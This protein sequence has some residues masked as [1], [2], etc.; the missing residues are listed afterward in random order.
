MWWQLHIYVN[1]LKTVKCTCYVGELYVNC[2]SIKLFLKKE[3][4]MQ[5]VFREKHREFG[6]RAFSRGVLGDKQRRCDGAR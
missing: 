4:K 5:S 6:I 3:M 2:I 1:I